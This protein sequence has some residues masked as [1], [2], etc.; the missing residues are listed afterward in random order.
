[1]D[2]TATSQQGRPC[3]FQCVAWKVASDLHPRRQCNSA[4]LSEPEIDHTLP[5]TY[6]HFLAWSP[7]LN[8]LPSRRLMDDINQVM[9]GMFTRTQSSKSGN[10]KTTG[11]TSFLFNGSC[12]EQ[13]G[14]HIFCSLSTSRTECTKL[15]NSKISPFSHMKN[16]IKLSNWAFCDDAWR[17]LEAR[18][19]TIHDGWIYPK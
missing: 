4:T 5:P 9:K 8:I 19:I 14:F 6:L 17:P 10:T 15:T 2:W 13:Y 11:T 7:L 1:M 18:N 3:F 12:I 16:I